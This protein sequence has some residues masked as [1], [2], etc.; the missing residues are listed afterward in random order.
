MPMPLRPNLLAPTGLSAILLVLLTGCGNGQPFAAP[1]P[2]VQI[3]ADPSANFSQYHS[4]VFLPG[5]LS[6]DP[7]VVKGTS[8][9]LDRRL[10]PML[11]AKLAGKG[12]HPARGKEAVDLY[13]TYFASVKRESEIVHAGGGRGQ[14]YDEAGAIPAGKEWG[15]RSFDAGSMVLQ[16][17]DAR[18]RGGVWRAT[19]TSEVVENNR[20][21][22]RSLDAALKS[23]PPKKK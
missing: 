21:L 3:A 17:T 2:K 13:I 8:D 15:I 6:A 22:D 5:Q 10:T 16:F 11:E 14:P 19:V 4:Y 1:A 20:V 18:T 12:L 7:A 9:D 23:Y